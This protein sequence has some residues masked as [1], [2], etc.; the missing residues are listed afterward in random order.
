MAHQPGNFDTSPVGQPKQRM[1]LIEAVAYGIKKN[2][3]AIKETYKAGRKGHVLKSNVPNQA[4]YSQD[5]HD[6]DL[7]Q[8]RIARVPVQNQLPPPPP[9]SSFPPQLQL[10]FE[11]NTPL[12][13]G[14]YTRNPP[15]SMPR[16]ERAY[17]VP[18]STSE[19]AVERNLFL[20][21]RSLDSLSNRASTPFNESS[22]K[23]HMKQV[24]APARLKASRIADLLV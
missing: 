13:N 21:S 23:G 8:P 3:S 19:S 5:E 24:S 2:S 6:T 12:G 1:G 11:S 4:P 7:S 22:G 10:T 9:M 15:T 16:N 17:T 14:N 18:V 20:N